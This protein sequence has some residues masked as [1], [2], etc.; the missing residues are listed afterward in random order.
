MTKMPNHFKEG[1][2]LIHIL[3]EDLG[4]PLQC[5]FEYT[6]A[7]RGAREFGTGLQLE[8]DYPA[9]WTLSHVY[10]PGS[11]VDIAPVLADVVITGLEEWAQDNAGG[12]S[13]DF[14]DDRAQ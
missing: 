14:D 10:L 9:T 3:H 7:E 6:P 12:F 1:L 2:H 8:P 11:D 4:V 13:D 5:W